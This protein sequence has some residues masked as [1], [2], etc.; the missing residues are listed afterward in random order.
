MKLKRENS[1]KE[2]IARELKTKN[3]AQWP[4]FR[5][6]G[7]EMQVAKLSRE[8]RR[9]VAEE[10]GDVLAPRNLFWGLQAK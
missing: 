9:W 7:V 2:K 1:M 5:W 8:D 3:T 6:D 4:R 10:I